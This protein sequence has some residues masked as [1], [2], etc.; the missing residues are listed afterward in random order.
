MGDAWLV[1]GLVWLIGMLLR[2][3]THVGVLVTESV[4]SCREF[5]TIGIDLN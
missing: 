1:R 3:N 4:L 2:R 5:I